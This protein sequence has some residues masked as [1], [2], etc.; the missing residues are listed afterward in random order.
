MRAKTMLVVWFA[1]FLVTGCLHAPKHAVA[2]EPWPLQLSVQLTS[3]DAGEDVALSEGIRGRLEET[4]KGRG[5]AIATTGGEAP[6]QV[7]IAAQARWYAQ[8]AGRY[9]WTVETQVRLTRTETDEVISETSF[10]VPVFLLYDHQREDAAFEQA[11]P[12]I[13]RQ[14]GDLLDR[15]ITAS[16]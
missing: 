7:H 9:R 1:T 15:W 8:L 3:L 6:V 4:C 13:E 11:L 2:P 14:L 5:L 16:E 10:E 12:V